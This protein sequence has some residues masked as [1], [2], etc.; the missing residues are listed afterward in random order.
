MNEKGLYKVQAV[1]NTIKR[2]LQELE[3]DVELKQWR[4]HKT[5][6]GRDNGEITEFT[7]S[8]GLRPE[9]KT[10]GDYN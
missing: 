10:L 3:D 7:L 9:I 6:I 8:M 5:F 4:V 1:Q 2:L